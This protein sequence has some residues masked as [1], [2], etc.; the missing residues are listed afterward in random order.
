ML[1]IAVVEDEEIH[2]KTLV[3]Y[4]RDYLGGREAYECATFEDGAE[5]LARQPQDLDIL[6]LD[7]VMG[8]SNGIDVAHTV[9]S[10][11]DNVIIIFVTQAVQYALEG[12]GVH[13]SDFLVKPLYYTSFCHSM[14]RALATLKRRAPNMLRIEFDKTTSYVDIS[15]ILYVETRSKGTLVHAQSGDFGCSESLRSLEER[16]GPLG[17]GRCHQAYLVNVTHVQTIRKTELLVGQ[18]WLP[19]SRARREAFV[20]L[21]VHEV[22]ATI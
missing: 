22:G 3:G 7:I 16:L 4:I 13:A 9:R 2:R 1:H 12:Y 21:L 19:I 5:F 17:F 18:A 20:S 10:H 15:T 8:H 6:F 14:Q 11:N